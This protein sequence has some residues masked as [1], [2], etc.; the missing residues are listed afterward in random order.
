VT[1]RHAL[2]LA[3]VIAL[4]SLVPTLAAA[5]G[6]QTGI[7]S[8][9][10]KDPEGLPLPGATVTVTSPGL[11]GSRTAVTDAIGAYIIRGL[12]PGTYMVQFQFTGTAD[13]KETIEVPLG[14]LAELDATLKLS[15]IQETVNVVADATPPQLATTQQSANY[16][17]ELIST[18]PIGRRPFEIAE[19]APGVTDNTPNAGQMA[20]GGAFAFDSIF[21]IDGVDTN[22][23]LFGTSN[24]LFVEDAIEETQVLTSGISAEFGRFGGG[25]INVITKSGGNQFHGSFRTNFSRPS[26]SDETP[27]EDA[28][29]PFVPRSSVL[30]KN[31]EGTVGGPVV[32][33]RLWFFNA[34]RYQDAQTDQIFAE[35]GGPYTTGTKNKRFELKLTG[36]PIVN[37]TVSGSFLNSPTEVT[38]NPTINNVMSMTA[39]TL[40]DRQTPN[41]LWVMNYNGVMSNK[42]FAT[43]QWSK[44][45]FGFRN[46]G[47]TSTALVDS[48]FITRGVLAGGSPNNR[49]FNA[50]YFDATDPED[51]NN[52][53]FAGSV[54]YFLTSRGTGR[55][56]LKTGF[57]HFK[58]FRNGGNSQSATGYVFRTDYM[59]GADGKPIASSDGE[60]IPIWGGNATGTAG[61]RLENWIPTRGATLD[62]KTLSLYLQDRWQAGNRVTMDLGVRYEKVRTD[63]TGDIVGA[64]TDTVVPRLGVS[65]DVEGNGRTIAQATYAR[66]S[67]RF[68]ERAFGRNTNVGTPSSVILG[69]TGPA[70]QGMG[71]APAFDLAN[72]IPLSGSFPTANVFFDDALTSPKTNEF[73]LALGRELKNGGYGKVIYTWRNTSDFIE[74]LRTDPTAAGK[75][76]VI[77]GGRNYGTFDNIVWANTSDQ[78]REYQALQF[79]SRVR[80]T[81][82]LFVEGH[83]TL[84]IK[85]HGNF[86]GEAANQ[87]GNGS[88]W[89]DY[90]EVFSSE[91]RYY[92]YGPLDEFQRHKV[93]IWTSYNQG[94]GRFGSVDIAP[95]WRINSGLTYS[96][97]ATAVPPSAI[98]QAANPGYQSANSSTATLF[99]DERGSESF[100]GYGLLDLSVRY[101]VPVWQTVQPWI[102]VAIFNVMNNQKLIQ[103]DTTVTRDLTGPV[104]AIG[105]PINYVKGP[106]FGKATAATNFPR[107]SSGENGGRTFRL[108]M[109]IRF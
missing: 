65:F 50:P 94:L 107:W 56:D 89:F 97:A 16:R 33:N 78:T 105:Q 62:I 19:L 95:I 21:L 82:K 90:P 26:W 7:L 29:V 12:P 17:S 39:S 31:Y 23:N 96:L 18:L 38:N 43:F 22:D 80:F 6:V 40:V 61:T 13:V 53:Q 9:I 1:K 34:D 69:Y 77:Q 106:N 67:G 4:G 24:N 28:R 103:W 10:V 100:K 98:Q 66:Y 27:F 84:Q 14:G 79:L 11:Q 76:T 88:I 52:K 101:G 2:V 55:H 92:P 25:V 72:Y 57:E 51:R 15:G 71:F 73:T 5:Q 99:F 41:S 102:Q 93:R 86:E 83:W 87:P 64:D 104:D 63:A 54:S 85:N 49:H 74:D 59:V 47:G 70:G 44:K 109:G 60:P 81:R 42:V 36:S 75:T 30:S 91:A 58:S 35:F 45:D 68:T 3:L 37:H 20:V 8:G 108:A 48:P 32:L 46:A